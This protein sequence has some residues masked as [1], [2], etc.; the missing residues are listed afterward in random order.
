MIVLDEIAGGVIVKG[1]LEGHRVDSVPLKASQ[2]DVVRERLSLVVIFDV[3]GVHE[4]V[5]PQ[6][7]HSRI[8]LVTVCR[9]V[10][11]RVVLSRHH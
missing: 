1:A 11:T 6:F 4:E 8:D 2:F 7:L 9:I 10:A 5:D 3:S